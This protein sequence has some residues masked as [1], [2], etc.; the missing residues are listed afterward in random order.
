MTYRLLAMS[1]DGVLLKSND[2]I[3]KETKEA[4]D[5]VRNKGV[6]TVLVTNRSFTSAKKV[7]KSLKLNQEMVVH[8]GAMLATMSGR[9]LYESRMQTELVYDLTEFMERFPCK[10][11]VESENYE[12]ENKH[13]QSG[14]KLGKVQFSIAE[15]LF[16][17]KTYT[18]QISTAVYEKQLTALRVFGQFDDERSAGEC[19]QEI[20]TRLPGILVEQHASNLTIKREEATKE[21]TL[22]YLMNE[23]RVKN[24]EMIYIGAGSGDIPALEMAGIGVAM[25]QSSAAVKEE[26]DW[27]TRSSDQD[28][29]AYMVKEVFRKQMK[30]E[31]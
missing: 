13:R 21:N 5:F 16:Q 22:A 6:Y 12:W 11:Q 8:G 29:V 20:L 24:E 30:V 10:I 26:A 27:I 9:P 18:S 17:P 2:R 3:S 14:K 25:G 1:I 4:L 7:A 23:L 15:G 31:V 19:R 28:G